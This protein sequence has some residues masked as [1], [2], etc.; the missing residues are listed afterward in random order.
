[1]VT[2]HLTDDEVQQYAVDK[3]NCEKRIAEHIHLCEECRAKAEVYQLMIT[4]IK[5]QP[6]PAFDFDLSAAVLKRLPASSPES[7]NDRL[8][9]WIFIF[10]CGGLIGAT[11]YFCRGYLDT[12]FKGIAGI[13]IYLISIS[14]I[15]IIVILFVEM[16]KKYQKEMRVLDLY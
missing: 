10:L 8:I 16:Y 9:T 1:M 5:Q 11:V 4:G 14:A 15:T 12:I 3:S 6:Q 2:K 7:A 13:S